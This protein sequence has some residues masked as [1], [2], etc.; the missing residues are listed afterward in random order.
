M[1]PALRVALLL[2]LGSNS[3]PTS[4][5]GAQ[6]ARFRV[7]ETTIAAVQAAFRAK[8]LTCHSLVQQYL[9]RIAAY[10]KRGPAINSLVVVNRRRSQCGFA[11]STLCSQRACRSVALQSDHCKDQLRD[12]GPADH[13]EVR[14]AR[15]MEAPQERHD[16]AQ[17]REAGAIV[18]AKSNLA[19]WAF[20][21][22]KHVSSI[23]PG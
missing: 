19:E 20:T 23:L 3:L 17:D 11:R 21:R 22:T 12:N 15:R 10:D 16:G 5:L 6:S 9:D 8:T 14:C 4:A 18:L 1:R 13:R 2:L 7:E